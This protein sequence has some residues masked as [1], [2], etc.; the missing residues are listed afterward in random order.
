MYEV[1]AEVI[2]PGSIR[3]ALCYVCVSAACFLCTASCFTSVIKLQVDICEQSV[4]ESGRTGFVHPRTSLTYL[5]PYISIFCQEL[6]HCF[7]DV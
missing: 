7:V 5:L 6:C 4:Y 3:S 2:C 1:D